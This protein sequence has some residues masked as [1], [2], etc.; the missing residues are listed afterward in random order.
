M[1]HT[2]SGDKHLDWDAY[3]WLGQARMLEEKLILELWKQGN[4]DYARICRCALTFLEE[5]HQTY[6]DW[7]EDVQRGTLRP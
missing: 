7:I 3:K 2:G 4:R 5:L 6:T 1:K